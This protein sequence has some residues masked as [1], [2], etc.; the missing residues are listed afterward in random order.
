AY[1]R[2]DLVSSTR[3]IQ[4]FMFIFFPIVY[5]VIMIFSM[6]GLFNELSF[7]IEVIMIT[8]SILL[9]FYL[10]IP[11]LLVVGFLNI[12][13]SG[14]SISASLPIIPRDQ[15]KAKLYLMLSIQGI[16]LILTS[17]ILAFLISSLLVIVLFVTTLP[18]AWTFLLLMLA[19]K[20]KFF[21]QMNYKYVI[22]EVNKR[23]KPGKW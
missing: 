2:K 12:E 18:I 13:E 19:L 8:W 3:D 7:S 21:G 10:I 9:I 1:I 23:N 11:I 14:S 15:V 22:E 4:S 20:V 17:T 16:S 6:I 5:P